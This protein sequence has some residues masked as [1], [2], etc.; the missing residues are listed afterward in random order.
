MK[1]ITW[2][3]FI[4]CCLSGGMSAQ[5]YEQTVRQAL[6]AAEHDSLDQAEELF[7]QAL[8]I[9]PGDHRN[10]LVYQ[11]IGQV[12]ETLQLFQGHRAAASEPIHAF[13]KGQFLPFHG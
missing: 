5:T 10:A 4:C 12:I 1:R 2:I 8:K 11:Y 9:S 13:L 3:A 7:R 6:S